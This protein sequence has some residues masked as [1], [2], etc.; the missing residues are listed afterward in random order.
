MN[1]IAKTTLSY[2]NTD[3][4]SSTFLASGLLLCTYV[5]LFM[6][7]THKKSM[8]CLKDRTLEYFILGTFAKLAICLAS[9]CIR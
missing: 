4:K 6:S 8:H 3:E 2:A 5:A 1:N 7:I 9:F